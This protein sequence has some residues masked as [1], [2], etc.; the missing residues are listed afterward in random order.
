MNSTEALSPVEAYKA[1]HEGAVWVEH[2]GRGMLHLKG[3]TRLE[4]I[5]RMSTQAVGK[6]QSGEG[7]ATV[8]TTLCGFV[9]VHVVMVLLSGPVRQ[10]KAMITGGKADEAA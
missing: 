10:I 9:L 2:A 3:S 4:L 5:N 8:L 7:A 1:A 6:L